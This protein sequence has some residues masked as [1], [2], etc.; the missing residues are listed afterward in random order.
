MFK[1]A[2]EIYTIRM[3]IISKGLSS[4]RLSSEEK[5]KLLKLQQKL[6]TDQNLSLWD[7]KELLDIS[8]LI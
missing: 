8:S 4:N 1:S 2:S 3:K 5:L 7:V 6:E